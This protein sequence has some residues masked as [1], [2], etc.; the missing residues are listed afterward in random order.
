LCSVPPDKGDYKPD[1]KCMSAL[2]LAWHIAMVEI[3]FLDA[4]IHRHFGETAPR[5]A[6][7]K[8]G[9]DVAEWYEENFARRIPL[10]EAIS[11][12]DLTTPVDF[13]WPKE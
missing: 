13:V 4:V 9:R 10:L 5:P 3:W 8:T 7:V 11:A 2:Q 12:E 1:A 6:G